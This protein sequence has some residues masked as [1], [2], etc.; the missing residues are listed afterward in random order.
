MQQKKIK[1]LKDKI[2]L[3]E[4]SLQQIVYDFE[5]EK[6]LLKFQHDKIISDQKSDIIK[7]RQI[8]KSRNKDLKNIRALS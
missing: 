3:L 5:K 4:K 1:I 6:E 2:I 8:L 7:C